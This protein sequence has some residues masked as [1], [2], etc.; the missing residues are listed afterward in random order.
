M[1]LMENPLDLIQEW[2][3]LE[4]ILLLMQLGEDYIEFTILKI[5][6]LTSVYPEMLP[7][8]TTVFMSGSFN[9]VVQDLTGFYVILM[10]FFMIENVM[11]DIRIDERNTDSLI[12]SMMND[13]FYVLQSCI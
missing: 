5:K 8:A 2:F 4:E 9:K 3:H 7:R 12:S 10:G 11:T 13:A 6:G 1:L